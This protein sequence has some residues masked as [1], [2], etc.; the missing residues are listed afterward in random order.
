MCSICIVLLVLV[1]FF[2]FEIS[3]LKQENKKLYRISKLTLLEKATIQNQLNP[4]FVFNT[5][6]RLQNDL[7][8]GDSA[9]AMENLTKFGRFM[10]K[11]LNNSKRQIISLEEELEHITIY[12]SLEKIRF[13]KGLE[14]EIKR[15][16]NV[17]LH[18]QRIPSLIVQPFLE[19]SV[20]NGFSK[21][22]EYMKIFIFLK[23]DNR[24][25]IISIQDSVDNLDNFENSAHPFNSI[26]VVKDRIKLLNKFGIK[27]SVDSGKL[28]TPNRLNGN[29][30]ELRFDIRSL[31]KYVDDDIQKNESVFI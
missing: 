13:P 28:N 1:A 31:N 21:G 5:M 24:D 10:R 29:I 18:N 25:L 15:S 8:I 9:V 11:T 17:D 7:A 4:H 3:R 20:L 30:V 14:F 23:T 22:S 6:A 19:R 27:C 12:L 26:D 16:E 2:G